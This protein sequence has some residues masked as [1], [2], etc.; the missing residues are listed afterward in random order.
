MSNSLVR[1]AFEERLNTWAIS[2]GL[3]V[4]WEN[5]ALFPPTTT[6]LR[7][8]V[9]RAA[10]TSQTLD[11]LHRQYRGVFQVSIVMPVAGGAGA[12]DALASALDALFPINVPITVGGLKVYLTSP[13]SPATGIQ[14]P[15]RWVVP[16][17]A[18]YQADTV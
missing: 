15:N 14:E 1:Q 17:S 6:Y 10:T 13:M 8:F 16:V 5:T 7:A 11:G 12:G 4:D 3:P 2:Q 18:Q 9:L